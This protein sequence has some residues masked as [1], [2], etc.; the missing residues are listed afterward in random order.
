MMYDEE[1][2]LVWLRL[3]TIIEQRTNRL[4]LLKEADDEKLQYFLGVNYP[5]FVV[6]FHIFFLFFF[7]ICPS[8]D[9]IHPRQVI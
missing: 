4:C 5:L 6:I 7:L 9:N 2:G 1:I 3:P 8:G